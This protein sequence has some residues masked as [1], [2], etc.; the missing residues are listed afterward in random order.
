MRLVKPLAIAFAVAF[1]GITYAGGD[2]ISMNEP[3][4]QS[5][6]QGGPELL[7]EAEPMDSLEQE[8]VAQE[9][10]VYD[11]YVIPSEI[12]LVPSEGLSEPPLAGDERG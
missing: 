3:R 6:E 1:S 4:F 10:E 11:V 9:Y 7:S 2:S 12:V 8:S 5:Y